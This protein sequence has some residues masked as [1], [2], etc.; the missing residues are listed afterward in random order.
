MCAMFLNITQQ[1]S[2]Q[3][4]AALVQTDSFYHSCFHFIIQIVCEWQQMVLQIATPMF[5]RNPASCLLTGKVGLF[6]QK[7]LLFDTHQSSLK[8]IDS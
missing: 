7:K 8:L 6:H 4:A 2:T 3:N 1:L 5:G